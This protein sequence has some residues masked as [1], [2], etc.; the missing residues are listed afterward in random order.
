MC[1][2]PVHTGGR[3][4]AFPV[5]L[6]V[7]HLFEEFEFTTRTGTRFKPPRSRWSDRKGCAGDA[8]PFNT[9][10]GHH[11]QHRSTC[12]IPLGMSGAN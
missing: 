4:V 11:I 10:A 2:V 9:F 8:H 7:N 3:P 12:G 5:E 6:E 1:G